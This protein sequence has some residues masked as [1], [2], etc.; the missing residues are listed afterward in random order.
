MFVNS[1]SRLYSNVIGVKDTGVVP[2]GKCPKCKAT[3]HPHFVYC[4]F[5]GHQLKDKSRYCQCGNRLS[6]SDSFCTSCGQ[7]A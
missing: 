6:S 3:T 4:G 2:S 1:K 5:C 7:K